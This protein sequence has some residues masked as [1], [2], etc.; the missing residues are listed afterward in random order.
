[1][2]ESPFVKAVDLFFNVV[3]IQARFGFFLDIEE[4]LKVLLLFR[5]SDM[6]D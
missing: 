1:M 6:D 5:W 2:S 3:T 4:Q